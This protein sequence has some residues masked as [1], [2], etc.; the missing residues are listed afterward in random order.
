MTKQQISSAIKGLRRVEREILYSTNW[1]DVTCREQ[2][3]DTVELQNRIN[4]G[5]IIV[6]R[7]ILKAR[8][9]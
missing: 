8:H 9:G 3:I 1:Q 4:E 5:K 7:E 2:Q 6:P